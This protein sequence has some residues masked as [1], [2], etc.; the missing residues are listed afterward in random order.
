VGR[1]RLE[2]GGAVSALPA[3]GVSCCG[4]PAVSGLSGEFVAGTA[5]TEAVRCRSGVG[6]SVARRPCRARACGGANADGCSAQ[7][8]VL[9]CG[10]GCFVA[11][12]SVRKDARWSG[13]GRG[14]EQAPWRSLRPQ[15]AK[16]LSESPQRSPSRASHYRAGLV[17]DV[18]VALAERGGRSVGVRMCCRQK[19]RNRPWIDRAHCASAAGACLPGSGRSGVPHSAWTA[20]DCGRPGR[21]QKKARPPRAALS[22]LWP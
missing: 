11:T 3:G 18:L 15:R 7:A 17:S 9:R 2:R 10:R 14:Q 19:H 8:R 13:C 16:R 6:R 4:R 21:A 22:C 20:L 12:G 5:C 1:R